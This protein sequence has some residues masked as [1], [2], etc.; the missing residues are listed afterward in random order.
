MELLF[1]L[2][3]GFFLL[4]A[5]AGRAEPEPPPV[6]YFVAPERRGGALPTFLGLVILVALVAYL[7]SSLPA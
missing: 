5:R 1:L 7:F 4:L 3:V 2:A 6:I